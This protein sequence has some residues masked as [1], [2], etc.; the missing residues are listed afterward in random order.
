MKKIAFN[1]YLIAAQFL[2]PIIAFAVNNT[3]EFNRL[4]SKY[5]S[6]EF[7]Y[8]V[9]EEEAKNNNNFSWL[10]NIANFFNY[11]DWEIVM[12]LIVALV[13]CLIIYKLYR[14]GILFKINH[15]SNINEETNFD[16][17]ENNLLEID[18]NQLIENAKLVNDY[19]LAIR[20]YHYQNTQNLAK[21]NLIKWN[22]KKT[23]QQLENEIKYEDIKELFK[24]NTQIFNQVWF[25]NFNLNEEQFQLFETNFKF[26][27]ESI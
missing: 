23:N 12:Y 14:N 7:N 2:F 1:P 11:I 4:K 21:K 10:M 17:I 5:N 9:A 3:D 16:Y 25:G 13:F 6:A 27:N 20:Y 18:L 15:N 24:S 19:R 26:L 8:V 22:P